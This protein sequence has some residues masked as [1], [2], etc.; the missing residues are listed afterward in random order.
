M[1]TPE[2][3]DTLHRSITTFLDLA[4]YAGQVI[5]VSSAPLD[6][7]L[8]AGCL[9]RMP[10][11]LQMRLRAFRIAHTRRFGQSTKALFYL[12]MLE[13]IDSQ[14]GQSRPTVIVSLSGSIKDYYHLKFISSRFENVSCRGVRLLSNPAVEDLTNQL[15]LATRLLP[16]FLT[17]VSKRSS[18]GGFN[19]ILDDESIQCVIC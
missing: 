10:N 17:S 6:D 1:A 4:E 15:I 3:I 2:S 18:F 11:G 16:T 14:V 13:A 7:P 9:A 19:L 5:L 8:L 12:R